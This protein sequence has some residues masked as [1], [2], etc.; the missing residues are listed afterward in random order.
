MSVAPKCKECGHRHFPSTQPHTWDTPRRPLVVVEKEASLSKAE[1][2]RLLKLEEDAEGHWRAF[3]G[4]LTTI[5]DERLFRADYPTFE[6]YCEGRWGISR[7]YGLRLIA[8]SQVVKMLP[9][10]DISMP[11][12][13]SERIARELIPLKEDPPKLAEAWAETLT[14]H[15]PKPTAEQTA[16]VVRTFQ[17][18]REELKEQELPDPVA[19][20][21]IDHT[22]SAAEK[23]FDEGV[24]QATAAAFD[25]TSF[26]PG[27]TF[28]DEVKRIAEDNGLDVNAVIEAA[29]EIS[30]ESDD[31]EPTDASSPEEE[32]ADQIGEG[33]RW[34]G[35]ALVSPPYL[36]YKIGDQRVVI[37]S[38]AIEKPAI[39]K[40][41]PLYF[42]N[43]A[44]EIVGVVDLDFVLTD[45]D[46]ARLARWLSDNG[47]TKAVHHGLA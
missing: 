13:A 25:M 4:T 31:L 36:E 41:V 24:R 39:E 42:L 21:I 45:A 12:P 26:P 3:A 33:I 34:Q 6:A 8:A 47:V 2:Q 37:P 38:P 27:W 43:L 17:P 46:E 18:S 9:M 10:G 35:E 30:V 20:V 7:S 29:Q 16:S 11:V 1:R 44:H 28:E 15:G 40:P 14:Q 19:L 22:G 32:E 5:R 23:T